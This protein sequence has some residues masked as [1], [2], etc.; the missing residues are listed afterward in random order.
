[1]SEKKND[2]NQILDLEIAKAISSELL[3]Y[4]EVSSL[5]DVG[6]AKTITNTVLKK[7]D[8]IQ[9]IVISRDENNITIDIYIKV[10][11]GVN[12]PQ[13]SYDIQSKIQPIIKKI[14]DDKITG[15]NINV[16]GLEER[17]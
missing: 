14:T 9:G 6:I 11:Y 12:I 5:A 16:E 3:N 4:D 7:E 2:H 17:G 13:L 8:S 15:I 10:Y 1:M